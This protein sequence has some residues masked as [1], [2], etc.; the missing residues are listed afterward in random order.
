MTLFTKQHDDIIT[1]Y[2]K[3]GYTYASIADEVYEALGD[4]RSDVAVMARAK[5]LKLGPKPKNIIDALPK[6]PKTRV[7]SWFPSLS[8]DIGIMDLK[9]DTCR[10]PHDN[11]K[12]TT[13]CGKSCDASQVYCSHHV[14]V[15][16]Q[17]KA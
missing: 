1:K 14:R 16:Y 5:R 11:G 7:L 2:Y 15:C 8:S 10:F 13:Y 3:A 9:C 17:R 6:D 12:E 4:R